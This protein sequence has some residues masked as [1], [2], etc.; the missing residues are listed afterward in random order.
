[1][2]TALGLWLLAAG[3]TAAA[4]YA[5]PIEDPYLA[6]VLGT[7]PAVRAP[8]P[9]RIRVRVRSLR[10]HEDRVIPPVFWNLSGFRYSLAP[11]P[12]KAPLIFLIAGTG[13]RFNSEKM[14][15]LQKVL[16][17]AGL[18]VVNLSS[19]TQAQ[20]IASASSTSVPG[21]M[22]ADVRDLYAVMQRIRAEIGNGLDISRFYLAGY[23]LGGTQA[24]FLAELDASERVFDFERVFLIN[25][26]VSLF[27][28]VTRLDD[29]LRESIPG[30]VPDLQ[31]LVHELFRKVT[32][33]FHQH[34]RAPI[35]AELL[36][37]VAETTGVSRR[38]LAALISVAF[39]ISSAT[40]L[41]TSDLMTDGGHVV[42]QGADLGPYSSTTPYLKVAARWSFADY[43]DDVLVP[44]WSARDPGLS[45]EALIDAGS[46]A[47]IEAFLSA[48]EHVYV[49][50]NADELILGPGD[51]EFLERTFGERATIYPTGGHCGNLMY[52]D[53]VAL[54]LDA[55]GVGGEAEAP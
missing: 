50:T 32:T 38:D 15:Y 35:D 31:R 42:E 16:H 27:T 55:L 19:P 9:E 13:A 14:I 34:G 7:P 25:P 5:F 29:M 43:L 17:Q 4:D 51:L 26:S 48:A 12:H 36:F 47:S 8:V 41:F 44:Y 53:N 37:H 28:S 24:A 40:M 3:P 1:M 22:K 30:G 6:T 45:R 11:Q 33:Y 52:R 49:V 54:M 23:S 39:R 18:H 21:N 10:L 20:F 2:E 46:L